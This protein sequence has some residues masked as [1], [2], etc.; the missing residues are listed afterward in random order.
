MNN[1]D[2]AETIMVAALAGALA[3]IITASLKAALAGL[4]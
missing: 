3:Y 2:R 1:L 4:F